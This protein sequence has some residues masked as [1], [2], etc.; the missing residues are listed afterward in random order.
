MHLWREITC[1]LYT[2]LSVLEGWI[3]KVFSFWRWHW[4]DIVSIKHV[5]P[6]ASRYL[7][8]SIYNWFREL[9]D[10]NEQR[11]AGTQRRIYWESSTNRLLQTTRSRRHFS[12]VTR[13][14]SRSLY[15]DITTYR[16]LTS[17][18]YIRIKNVKNATNVVLG[19]S[20]AVSAL[21]IFFSLI[22]F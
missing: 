6:D 3:P 22:V 7:D 16:T 11:S 10:R 8:L 12:W 2:V 13:D 15:S 18:I 4:C 19:G 5:K 17:S 1:G 9:F 14:V 20:L 21:L